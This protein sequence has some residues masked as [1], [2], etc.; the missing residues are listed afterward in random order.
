MIKSWK[1]ICILDFL[2]TDQQSLVLT[3]CIFIINDLCGIVERTASIICSNYCRRISLQHHR[4]MKIQCQKVMKY[5][6]LV[7]VYF[8]A[9]LRW[10]LDLTWRYGYPAFTS[11]VALSQAYR[12]SVI[13]PG[14]YVL[15]WIKFS[16][17]EMSATWVFRWT[18]LSC[19]ILSLRVDIVVLF[20]SNQVEA[21][22]AARSVTN[23]LNQN[24]ACGFSPF[25]LEPH[26]SQNW[27]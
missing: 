13:L 20:I 14:S 22:S 10:V 2:Y 7:R 23:A 27:R 19:K 25:P 5:A 12:L 8:Q 15:P 26:Q 18:S 4:V 3:D 16:Y 6:Y 11:C 24:L 17:S 1:R 21:S 9:L